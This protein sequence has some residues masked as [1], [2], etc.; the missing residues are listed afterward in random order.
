MTS[1]NAGV[2]EN[3]LHAEMDCDSD[4]T[5]VGEGPLGD[6]EKDAGVTPAP[7]SPKHYV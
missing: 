2:G 5:R 3:Q 4:V 1:A 6:A 7:G